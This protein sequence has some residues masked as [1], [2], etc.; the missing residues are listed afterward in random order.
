MCRH[1]VRLGNDIPSLALS[2]VVGVECV[3]AVFQT[4]YFNN[5]PIPTL[6]YLHDDISICTLHSRV[7]QCH[8]NVLCIPELWNIDTLHTLTTKF[9]PHRGNGIL[10]PSL[11]SATGG[12]VE[13][14][15]TTFHTKVLECQHSVDLVTTFQSHLQML[16]L[17]Q[18]SYIITTHVS[19]QVKIN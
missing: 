2:T 16:L 15:V 9:Q 13:C 3:H 17:A 10:S 11:T 7:S 14:A 8:S 18:N 4:A 5:I 6:C 1:F 12:R 19:V